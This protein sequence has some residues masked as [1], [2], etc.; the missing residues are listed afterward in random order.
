MS[1]AARFRPIRARYQRQIKARVKT[2]IANRGRNIIAIVFLVE[3]DHSSK[4]AAPD[5]Y[6]PACMTRS[7]A[8]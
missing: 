4:I 5:N 2:R 7:C 6:A 3:I 8:S 1:F